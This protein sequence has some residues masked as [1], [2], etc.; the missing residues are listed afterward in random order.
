MMIYANEMNDNNRE[1][2][3][4]SIK[5]ITVLLIWGDK[6]NEDFFEYR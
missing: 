6:N 5:N 2:L 1:K 4:D 3:I